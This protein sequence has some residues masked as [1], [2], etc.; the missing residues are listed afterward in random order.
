MYFVG[1]S[2]PDNKY[3][4]LI[5]ACLCGELCRYDGGTV[6]IPELSELCQSGLALA[7]CPELEGGLPTP[8]PPCERHL[9]R[10]V[11]ASGDDK[12]DFYMAG[13]SKTLALAREHGIKVAV[14][15]EKSPSCGTSLIYDG[16]FSRKLV[17]G[18]GVTAELLQNSGIAVFS[19]DNFTEA[20]KLVCSLG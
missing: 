1:F 16:T 7:V 13:A 17:P 2:M 15:K 6:L 19:D 5:S 8:R 3:L 4:L 12:T 18:R 20:L 14:L 11:T 9:G 10:V